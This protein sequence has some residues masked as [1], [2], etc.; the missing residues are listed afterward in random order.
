MDCN[1]AVETLEGVMKVLPGDWIVTG[2]AG[3]KYPCKNE[4]FQ[5]TYE[6]V[7]D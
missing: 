2:I 4:I 5:K 3:E 1:A 7:E 6:M